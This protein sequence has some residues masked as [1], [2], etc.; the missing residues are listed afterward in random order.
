MPAHALDFIFERDELV[1]LG[2]FSQGVVVGKQSIEVILLEA[3]QQARGTGDI[4][5]AKVAVIP[6]GS[7]FG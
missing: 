4:A 6:P 5:A 7:F 3:V 1:P 2:L